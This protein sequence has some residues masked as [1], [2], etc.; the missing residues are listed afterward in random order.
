MSDYLQCEQC[1]DDSEKYIKFVLY[2]CSQCAKKDRCESCIEWAYTD[3][4]DSENKQPFCSECYNKRED[5]Q[6][7]NNCYRVL[8]CEFS[9]CWKCHRKNICINCVYDDDNSS[10]D[11][12]EKEKKYCCYD[13]YRV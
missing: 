13:C 12:D 9:T 11:K 4:N 2:D 1:G 3:V 5:I 6:K 10:E 8:Q 7:C